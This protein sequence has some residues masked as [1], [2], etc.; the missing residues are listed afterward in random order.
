M[1]LVSY[2]PLDIAWGVEH[3]L[4]AQANELRHS[5]NVTWSPRAEDQ[6]SSVIHFVNNDVLGDVDMALYVLV[7]SGLILQ[8]S[9]Q[10][11]PLYCVNVD[12]AESLIWCYIRLL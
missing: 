10:S 4:Y 7:R 11:L 2:A 6:L 3:E 8:K 12:K 9:C 5:L 1:L